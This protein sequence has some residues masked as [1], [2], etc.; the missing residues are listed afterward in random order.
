MPVFISFVFGTL[1]FYLFPYFPF[2]A[3]IIFCA[4]ALYLV[5]KRK[6]F[7]IPI[8]AV[9]LLYAFFRSSPEP[10]SPEL[11]N[12]EIRLTGTFTPETTVPDR[13]RLQTFAADRAFDPDSGEQIELLHGE[14]IAVFSD[15]EADQADQYELILKTGRDRTRLNPG[16]MRP[17]RLYGTIVELHEKGDAPYSLSRDLNSSRRDLNDYVIKRFGRDS[18]GLIAAITTGEMSVLDEG[19]RDAFNV[20]GLAHMLSISGAHFGLFSVVIFGTFVFLIRR[21][22]YRI[23]QRVTLVASPPQIA[24]FLCLPFMLLYLGISGWSVPAVRSFIMISLFLA[25]LLIGR[26]GFWL[27]SLLFAAFLLV[28]WTPGVILSLSFQLSFVAVLFI[29]FSIE[30]D[31]DAP[32]DTNRFIRIIKKSAALTLAAS[33]GTAVLAAYHFHY[34][35]LISPLSNLI[36]A[37]VIGFVLVP[38][39]VMS[40][41]SYMITGHYILAYPVGISAGFSVW[42]VRLMSTIPFADIRIP[43]FPPALCLFFYAGFLPYFILGKK[44]RFLAVPLIPLILYAAISLMRSDDLRITF[45]DVGQGDSAVIELPERKVIVVD[46]GRTGREAALFLR[47]LGKKEIDALVVTHAHPDHSGGVAYLLD[48]FAVKELWDSGR[49]QYPGG[50][51]QRAGRRILERGDVMD[52]GRY[53]ITALHPYPGFY[54]VSGNEYGDE[55][56]DSLVLKISGE[57]SSIL[58][59]GDIEEEALEDLS[60]LDR[61]ISSDVI[62]VPHHGSRTSAHERFLAGVSPAAAVISVGR[63]N[64]F[65]HPSPEMLEMLGR[66]RVLRT[67]E[68]GAVKISLT[69][70]G[71]GVRTFRE[72]QLQKAGSPARELDNLMRIFSCW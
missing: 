17:G 39:S 57:K 9:G 32:D 56:N 29:G 42:L 40:S 49:I 19:I 72:F 45:L 63:D 53:G 23:L 11:W 27:N 18:A 70:R 46:T 50:L 1:L 30:R 24:A 43:G 64:S 66:Q 14:D 13:E 31:E 12:R 2:S 4:A 5:F 51:G 15:F 59:A 3:G 26:K 61:W 34:V 33:L 44:K 36:A 28:L 21:L 55:N 10:S 71:T 69:D 47:Y 67:D 35:S 62:K 65:G 8:I 52:A 20:T 25:G 37:P 58:L 16:G 68:A 6:F 41:L 54:S 38:L 48:R 7:L 60:H 22:P